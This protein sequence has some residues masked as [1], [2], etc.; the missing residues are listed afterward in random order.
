MIRIWLDCFTFV[1]LVNADPVTYYAIEMASVTV[2]LTAAGA[3][4]VRH[5]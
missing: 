4:L 3:V 1:H 2:L 5:M